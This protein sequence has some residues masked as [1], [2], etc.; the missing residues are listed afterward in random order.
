VLVANILLALGWTAL[1]GEFSLTNLTIGFGIGYVLLAAMTRVDVL[2]SSYGHKAGAILSLFGFV[3]REF[4][5][6]NLKM[7]VDVLG[8]HD[9][10]RPGIVEVPI[11]LQDE[12]E[13][14]LLTTLINLTPGTLCLDISEDQ[15]FLYVHVMD[16]SDADAARLAI[17]SE[18]ERRVV[19]VLR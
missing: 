1:Q 11:D 10:L 4:V 5:T 19:A 6:A 13:L 16:A 8:S 14:L 12:Y 9:R 18:F 3:I 15:R 17:K 7:A 2:P